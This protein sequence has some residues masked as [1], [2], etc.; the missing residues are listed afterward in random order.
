MF[1]RDINRETEAEIKAIKA[2]SERE[3][4]AVKGQIRFWA[5]VLPPLP[6]IL[7]GLFLGISRA[8]R[9]RRNIVEERL[10]K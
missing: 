2:T 7:L 10:L 1:E 4:N 6:A 8:A 5:I 3:V 9:E